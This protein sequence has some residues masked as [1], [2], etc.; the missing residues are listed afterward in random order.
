[1]SKIV[2]GTGEMS[3]EDIEKNGEFYEDRIFLEG[4][5]K[6]AGVKCKVKPF[7]AYQGPYAQLENGGKL[8]TIEER[9][10]VTLY[11]EG[12]K[13]NKTLS[14]KKMIEFLQT[15]VPNIKL[16]HKNVEKDPTGL[17]KERQ[18]STPE[19]RKHLQLIKSA[20]RKILASSVK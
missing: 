9:N 17:K 12:P 1:M 2:E 4:I 11:Y 3:Q 5:C 18:K 19:Q 20:L 13:G 8:W 14:D 6:K 7:D 15:L 10:G 16:V